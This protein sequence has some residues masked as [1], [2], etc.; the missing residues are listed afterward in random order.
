MLSSEHNMT[1]GS[2]QYKFLEQDL[3]SINRTI[4]PFV[5]VELHRPM[6]I[7]KKYRTSDAIGVAMRDEIEDLLHL[8]Q[9]DLVISGHYHS[10]LQ[11]CEGLYRE[12]CSSGGPQ[13]V[14]IGTGGAPLGCSGR[15]PNGPIITKFDDEHFGVGR[16][17][18]YN[19]SALHFEFVGLGEEVVYDFWLLRQR[20]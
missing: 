13:Y 3:S 14:T 12:K 6:Y 17:S 15:K 1:I 2:A 10:Y 16:V 20:N 7:N 19:A 11:S 9:V 4:T 8:H 5:V 18:V